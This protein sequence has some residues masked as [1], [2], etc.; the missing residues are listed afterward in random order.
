MKKL[1]SLPFILL[2]LNFNAQNDGDIYNIKSFVSDNI[3]LIKN[4][5]PK[6]IKDRIKFNYLL[7]NHILRN[8]GLIGSYLF[9]FRLNKELKLKMS[10]NQNYIKFKNRKIIYLGA[11]LSGVVSSA[12]VSFILDP[13]A[14]GLITVFIILPTTAVLSLI[15]IIGIEKNRVS[16][17]KD[18]FLLVNKTL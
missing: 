8:S 15:S 7:R 16:L 10:N 12:T 3:E 5:N 4:T 14:V 2:I 13:L 11:L 6:K 18:Y 17:Y 9:Q 1:I